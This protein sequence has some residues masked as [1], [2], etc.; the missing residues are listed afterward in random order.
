[1]ILGLGCLA[2]DQV[3]FTDTPWDTGKGRI[4][5]RETRIGGNARNALATVAALG[6]PAAYVATVGTSSISEQAMGDLV[7]HG[8]DT[9]YIERVPGAD[10]VTAT[11]TVTSGGD[12]Y[13]AFDDSSLASTPLPAP[14]IVDD[15][16]AAADVILVDATNAPPGS[17]QMMER[18][19]GAGI[20]VIVDAERNPTPDMR[21]LMDVADHLVIPLGLGALITGQDEPSSVAQR[22]WSASRSAIVL[23]DGSR[24]AYAFGAPGEMA[25]VTAFPVAAIDTT[26]CGDA[27]HGAYAWG[28]ATGIDLVERVTIASA[29]AAVVAA[30]PAGVRRVAA[31]TDI[32]QVRNARP[33]P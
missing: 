1:M 22:L 24:G 29:A 17:L 3:L 7:D 25:H 10:P 5:R 15:A 28:I 12:R 20:P 2:Y 33:A 23:T 32:E 18:A 14:E 8:I 26:G 6:Y 11:I 19:R 30:L 16:L 31:W 13:I 9:R 21:A 27:F 4:L